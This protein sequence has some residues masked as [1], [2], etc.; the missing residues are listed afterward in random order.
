[1]SEII[2]RIL[3]CLGRPWVL[4]CMAGALLLVI[5]ILSRR[6]TQ[7]DYEWPGQRKSPA[8]PILEALIVFL[9][10]GFSVL[11]VSGLT[12]A[13]N[14]TTWFPTVSIFSFFAEPQASGHRV[15]VLA[16]PAPPEETSKRT[17]EYERKIEI[18]AVKPRHLSSAGQKK[19]VLVTP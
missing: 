1:M 10:A 9:I 14:R 18:I 7:G 15:L 16:T 12:G 6:K 11:G 4:C 13:I 17:N 2:H 19:K 5:L 3:P 8:F